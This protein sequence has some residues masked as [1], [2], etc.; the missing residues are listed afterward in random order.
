MNP[1]PEITE[2]D[3][4]WAWLDVYTKSKDQWVFRR[5]VP[6]PEDK[7][8]EELRSSIARSLGQSPAVP[9]SFSDLKLVKRP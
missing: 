5:R 3:D 1:N 7:T 9:M 2:T 4:T 6:R 8:F